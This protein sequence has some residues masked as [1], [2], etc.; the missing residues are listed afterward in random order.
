MRICNV[1]TYKK[2]KTPAVV[3]QEDRLNVTAITEGTEETLTSE[4]CY[5][6]LCTGNKT[7]VPDSDGDIPTS[8]DTIETTT[9]DYRAAPGADGV[10]K[11]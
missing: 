4:D 8:T 10:V 1:P 5:E 2:I 6:F 3:F 9:G 11:I 7:G